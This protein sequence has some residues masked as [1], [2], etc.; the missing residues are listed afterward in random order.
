MLNN[1]F[2][3]HY[4]QLTFEKKSFYLVSFF[5]VIV[6][7]SFFGVFFLKNFYSFSSFYFPIP[8]CLSVSLFELNFLL[9]LLPRKVNTVQNEQ[10]HTHTHTKDETPSRLM[11]NRSCDI[12]ILLKYQYNC[13]ISNELYFIIWSLKYSYYRIHIIHY[14]IKISI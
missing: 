12:S 13:L 6:Q 5:L 11:W 7:Y 10:Q 1:Y 4:V 14:E 3:T 9:V 2:I 8:L